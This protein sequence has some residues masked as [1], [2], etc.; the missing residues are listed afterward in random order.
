MFFS[1]G[2]CDLVFLDNPN[3]NNGQGM[4]IFIRTKIQ[5]WWSFVESAV[6]QI[7]DDTLEVMGG[8]EEQRYWINGEAG[9]KLKLSAVQPF[10]IGGNDVR[11]RVTSESQFQFKIFL[12]NGQSIALRSVKDFMK[13]GIERHSKELYG[14]S[15]GLMGPYEEGKMLARDG[16]T[17]LEDPNEFGKEWQV[18]ASEPKLFHNLQGAQH[19]ETCEMPTTTQFQRRLGERLISSEA[20]TRACLHVEPTDLDNC[21]A[22]VSATGD[23]AMAGAF[24]VAGAY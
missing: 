17:I 11:F 23:V 22:D 10:T 15:M 20:A 18:L 16:V 8:I 21:I 2:G 5:R 4:R 24:D 13:V 12:E 6:V 1:S 7:G 3:Y 19:P 9:P 14:G